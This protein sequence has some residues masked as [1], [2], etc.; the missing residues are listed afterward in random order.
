MKTLKKMLMTMSLVLLTSFLLISCAQD[1]TTGNMDQSM[2]G[3]TTEMT[4]QNMG[5]PMDT[6]E[7]E[8]MDGAMDTMKGDTMQGEMDGASD[9]KMKDRDK[10]M[11]Q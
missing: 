10:K 3:T 11:M 4:L 2:K 7:K 5:S 9:Q 6:M 8:N 1:N